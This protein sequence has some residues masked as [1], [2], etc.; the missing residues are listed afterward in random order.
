MAEQLNI[1]LTVTGTVYS[2]NGL[3]S[4]DWERVLPFGL[5]ILLIGADDGNLHFI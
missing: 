2:H 3:K 5:Q 1:H 4:M